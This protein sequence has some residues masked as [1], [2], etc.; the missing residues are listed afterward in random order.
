[1]SGKKIAITGATGFIGCRFVETLLLN[2]V[3]CKISALIRNYSSLA[4][5]ARFK[6]IEYTFGNLDQKEIIDK[7][8]KDVERL[9]K[10]EQPKIRRD[11]LQYLWKHL[12]EK[13][14]KTELV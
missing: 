12:H 6:S 11:E 14:M 4:H 7:F 10:L 13:N 9:K 5:L 1:M 8:V 2:K 3:D